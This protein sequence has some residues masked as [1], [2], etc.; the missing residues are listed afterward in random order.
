MYTQRDR[1]TEKLNNL[2]PLSKV[3]INYI[4]FG[5]NHQKKEKRKKKQKQKTEM[6]RQMKIWSGWMDKLHQPLEIYI[7]PVLQ[8]LS[9]LLSFHLA[10]RKR[11]KKKRKGRRRIKLWL[12][13][14]LELRTLARGKS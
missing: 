8:N 1:E 13:L 4:V 14:C 9:L 12:R 5:Y 7:F 6:G 3:Y 2:D 11:T 10:R